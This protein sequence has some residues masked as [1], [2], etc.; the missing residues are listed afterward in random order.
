MRGSHAVLFNSDVGVERDFDFRS[1]RPAKGKLLFV[2]C[3]KSFQPFF[4]E[5]S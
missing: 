4:V 3:S 5:S 2:K 1:I